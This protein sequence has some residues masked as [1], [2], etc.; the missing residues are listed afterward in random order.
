MSGNR[1]VDTGGGVGDGFGLP[2]D[3]ACRPGP[4]A[5]ASM[6]EAASAIHPRIPLKDTADS[7]AAV[8]VAGSP[9]RRPYRNPG[10]WR[11]RFRRDARDSTTVPETPLSAMWRVLG[12]ADDETWA[13]RSG[14]RGARETPEMTVDDHETEMRASEAEG[15]VGPRLEER[16]RTL[17]EHIPGVATYLPRPG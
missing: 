11:K 3:R 12:S 16:F 5:V 2:L 9:G 4:Q 7:P 14:T 15:S 10:S 8:F 1:D 6:S 13:P 17:V